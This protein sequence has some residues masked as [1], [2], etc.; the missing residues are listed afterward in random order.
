M[1]P[2]KARGRSQVIRPFC[3]QMEDGCTAELCGLHS[4]HQPEPHPI[5]MRFS[6]LICVIEITSSADALPPATKQIVVSNYIK[7]H[8]ISPERVVLK[9]ETAYVCPI[10]H[11]RGPNF[12]TVRSSHAGLVTEKVVNVLSPLLHLFSWRGELSSLEGRTN[13]EGVRDC[14]GSC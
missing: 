12:P 8:Q 1:F 13:G 14:Q 7:L 4:A 5:Q 2:A 10:A 6:Y 9:K 3:R 11:H